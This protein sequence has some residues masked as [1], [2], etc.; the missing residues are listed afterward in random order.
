MLNSSSYLKYKALA[1]ESLERYPV[2]SKGSASSLGKTVKNDLKAVNKAYKEAKKFSERG[3][4]MPVSFEWIA[5]N[6]YFIEEKA[7]EVKSAAKDI[8]RI[9]LTNKGFPRIY[10]AFYKYISEI[11]SSLTKETT[12]A[13]VNACET[14]QNG[15]SLEF[16]DF[17]AFETLFCASVISLTS[18][19]CGKMLQNPYDESEREYERKIEKCVVSLK[20]LSTYSFDKCF[21]KCETEEY[22]KLDP[23]GYYA[24][25]TKKTKDYYR[26]RISKIARKEKIS[27]TKAARIILEKAKNGA[28][29]KERHIGYYLYPHKSSFTKALYFIV[30][31]AFSAGVC[32][33]AGMVNPYAALA[34]FPVWACVKA[35]TDKI[36][37]SFCDTPPFPKLELERLP[38]MDGVIVVITTLLFGD[39]SD[40]EIFLKLENLYLSN[41]M[42]NAYFAILGDFPDADRATVSK[43]G[44]TV[45]EA[46]SRI[47]ALREKYGDKF[48]LFMRNRS[49]SKTQNAFMGYERKRGAV[50]DLV[51]FLCGKNDA[52]SDSD[53]N[54][55]PQKSVC[56][57]I[58]YIITLDAD[59][60]MPI[61]A[62]K[63]LAGTMLHPLNR[64]VID[65]DAK[66][67]TSGYGIMQ[68]RV[69]TGL[70]SA[71]KTAFSRIMCG[72]GGTEVYS[73]TQFDLYQT[74]FEESVFC[75]KGII[76][77]YAYQSVINESENNFKK[78]YVLSH[79]ILEGSLLRTALVT[80]VN[81]T[82]S[83]PKNEISYFKRYHR[84][85]R[86]DFQNLY[87]LSDYVKNAWD[88]TVK[89]NI[90]PLSKFKIFDNFRREMTP[91]FALAALLISC[92]AKSGRAALALLSLLYIV[93][94][95]ITEL[96]D[97]A[98]KLGF[99]CAARRYF[100]KG[101]FSGTL[102]GFLRTLLYISML[103]K[104]AYVTLCAYAKSFYRTVFSHK[105]LLEWTTASQSEKTSDNV[106][107]YITNNVFSGFAGA[108]IILFA[109]QGFLRIIGILWF[110]Y[111]LVSYIISLPYKGKKVVS[112]DEKAKIKAYAGDMWKFFENT[113]NADDNFLPVDNVALYPSTSYAHRTSP[114]N[115]G[116]YLLCILCARDFGFIDTENMYAR[117]ENTLK[118]VSDMKKWKGHLYNWYD[119]TDLSVLNPPFVSGVDCGNFHA[120]LVTVKEGIKKYASEKPEI[121]STVKKIDALLEGADL[122]DLYDGQ[123]ELFPIGISFENEK[124]IM[125]ENCYDMLMSESRTL[126][127]MAVALRKVGKKHWGVLSRPLVKKNDRV[128]IA[129]W[130]GTAFE[131]FMPSIFMPSKRASALYEALRFAFRCERERY[132]FS[133]GYPKV[134][135]I[136]ESGYYSFDSDMNY[137]YKAFGVPETGLKRGL[138]DD[139]VI[140][141]YSSFLSMCVN[142]KIPLE[143]LSKLK[144]YGMYGKYGFYEAID[145]TKDRIGKKPAVIKSYMSHHV[146][147]SI[148]ACANAY[149]DNINVKRFMSEP[150]MRS[151]SGILEEKIPVDAVVRK[152]KYPTIIKKAAE[153]YPESIKKN[154]EFCAENEPY[155]TVVS[156]GYCGAVLTNEGY[157]NAFFGE[158]T[159]FTPADERRNVKNGFFNLLYFGGKTYSPAYLPFENENV[160]YTFADKGAAG[161]FTVQTDEFEFTSDFGIFAGS[162]V[163]YVKSGL[164]VK[165]GNE[166]GGKSIAYMFEPVL[167]NLNENESHKAFHSLFVESGYEKDEN[168]LI[169]RRRS[170]D[171]PSG[172]V[173]LA[174]GLDNSKQKISFCTRKEELFSS[175]ITKDDFENVFTKELESKTGA[176][177]FPY[178][179][180]TTELIEKTEDESDLKRGGAKYE[181]VLFMTMAK[182]E[183]EAIESILSARKK[184]IDEEYEKAENQN[185]MMKISSQLA[186]ENGMEKT[187]SE[188]LKYAVYPE[189]S[190]SYCND[191]QSFGRNALWECGISGDFPIEKIRVSEEFDVSKAQKYCRAFMFLKKNNVNI[192]F[193]ILCEEKD[194]YSKP[195]EKAVLAMLEKTG[196]SQYLKKQNGGI[197]VLNK[198]N[199]TDKGKTLH[200]FSSTVFDGI[201]EEKIPQKPKKETIISKSESKCGKVGEKEGCYT[202]EN[203]FFDENNSFILTKKDKRPYSFVL[204]NG[205][206]SSVVT[207]GSLGY[208]FFENSF[209]KRI[210]PFRN[211]VFS[212][213]PGEKLYFECDNTYYDL[214]SCSDSVKYG[215][216]S[217]EYYGTVTGNA[218]TVRVYIPERMNCKVIEV[219]TAKETEG[220]I[221][222]ALRPVMGSSK[223]D[224]KVCGVKTEENAAFFSNPFSEN[225]SK[226]AGFLTCDKE[227]AHYS[228]EKSGIL[229]NRC[230]CRVKDFGGKTRFFLGVC[231]KERKEN[232]LSEIKEKMND[233]LLSQALDFAKKYMPKIRISGYRSGRNMHALA[234]MFNTYLSY[235]NAV[236]RILARSGFYQ[237]GGAYGFRD[238]L[239]D[240]VC[241]MY[242]DKKGAR[243]LILFFASHQ[244]S[245]G[246]AL[247]WWHE[248]EDGICKGIRSKC[249]DDYLWLVYALCEYVFY[250][251]D[252]SILYENA[253][254]CKGEELLLNEREKYIKTEKTDF[255]E[256][257]F[258]HAAKALDRGYKN[259][260]SRGLCLLG[261]G[262]WCD[263]LNKAGE[264]MKGESVWLSMFLLSI[265]EK[266][267]RLCDNIGK[268]ELADDYRRKAKTLKDNIEKHAFD[269][270]GGYYMRA[271][272]D[273]GTP[274]GKSDCDECRIDLISQAFAYFSKCGSEKRLLSA[275][276]KA[277]ENLYDE[278]LK[279]FRL[280]A[281]PFEK[282]AKNPGYIKGYVPGIRENG[283]QYTHAAI[284]GCMAL[285]DAGKKYGKKDLTSK[286]A[287]ALINLLPNVKS[288]D[289]KSQN[290]YRSEPYAT[291]ADVYTNPDFAGLG[292]WSWYTGSAG[293]LWSAVLRSFFGITLCNVT[294]SGKA[295]I[296][297]SKNALSELREYLPVSLELE[298]DELSAKYT[299]NFLPEEPGREFEETE[300]AVESGSKNIDVYC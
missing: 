243:D 176:C 79:D 164:A 151:A 68:P 294:K 267:V 172:D 74:V 120:C 48:Y 131:Y 55:A 10:K 118:T 77:K 225:F 106:I 208:T 202:L 212:D 142:V 158:K 72:A 141:P 50:S 61:D 149:F 15:F 226:S 179:A 178:C 260:G 161:T 222:F 254:Y 246:S 35:L 37:S 207:T 148:C 244:F 109:P 159:L 258:G 183:R 24:D 125:S 219:F 289:A 249:S 265:T 83:F 273:D 38:D 282:T 56:A 221:V 145:F 34:F 22:L 240:A 165:N 52:F 12:E 105:K 191:A 169:F 150:H 261:S 87:Y 119:T 60:E 259:V 155:C 11:T 130:S 9:Q 107:G 89:N 73:F 114:T 224:E 152:V 70:D 32:A 257:I 115:I 47:S 274:I 104:E 102:N 296:I 40:D 137:R 98:G 252:E 7:L 134:W 67:V 239:Q 229:E 287:K 33:S 66:I 160:K 20:F 112:D 51:S 238:Q 279:I 203:G 49:Y 228:F 256:S 173:F 65:E 263:G 127:Y 217:A 82:D 117:L 133:S 184:N 262:D 75:G 97:L 42:E 91:V 143:N 59:T 218:Y 124:E 25:M 96:I 232:A 95:F 234:I 53:I 255:S 270:S 43:D 26:S 14:P 237:S 277:Y 182:S 284:W 204:S 132:A 285:M 214:I 5:D 186:K 235:Q 84:W 269:E 295:K 36:Y 78:D 213:M 45:S 46:K 163:I 71:R 58:R 293:W 192:D 21:E 80:D 139:L 188:M 271:W 4:S 216:G 100:S 300:I 291:S 126:S 1:K 268:V 276:N 168:I 185:V 18:D 69:S 220:N 190:R 298:F 129:S 266:F 290:L 241:L 251:G 29:E 174:L 187:V 209:L 175:P 64:P 194:A 6:Y 231:E 128:G 170:R 76:D 113:V 23:S 292:G 121:I 166:K 30:I 245:D 17:Y 92:F 223:T 210:T 44:K 227:S 275:L 57:K 54:L 111:P 3:I 39:K 13:F 85:A 63:D 101:V 288:K 156:D 122:K 86:G 144:K 16:S 27:E 198:E 281:P 108:Y 31:T 297:I 2:K 157:F 19:I 138:E 215:A 181:A 90:S 153:R 154:I 110:L 147:M 62:L 280:F 8:D 278:E 177:I 88:K 135:G 189:N 199:L 116:L 299:L 136:S 205:K 272:Y 146:G 236:C 167:M 233:D 197:F 247:H 196:A 193:V 242:S 99:E 200:A 103:P 248:L 211:D 286:G 41:G 28:T 93:I 94:P 253:P 81:F 140:S 180:V 171:N 162:S 264:N 123:K 283:G 195:L 230:V 250:S 201:T 206:L